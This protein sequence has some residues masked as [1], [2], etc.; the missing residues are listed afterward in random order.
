MWRLFGFAT[1]VA[2]VRFRHLSQQKGE[3]VLTVYLL[4][5]NSQGREAT[6]I[7]CCHRSSGPTYRQIIQIRVDGH[8]AVADIVFS[9]SWTFSSHSPFRTAVKVGGQLY[10]T[11]VQFTLYTV[12]LGLNKNALILAKPCLEERTCFVRSNNFTKINLFIT[13]QCKCRTWKR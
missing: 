7:V 6:T 8:S 1:E 4:K 10:C 11:L 9:Q 3:A 12:K 13:I 2:T 5:K